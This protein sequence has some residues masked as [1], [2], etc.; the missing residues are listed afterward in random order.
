MEQSSTETQVPTAMPD[1]EEEDIRE[2]MLQ[3]ESAETLG[4]EADCEDEEADEEAEQPKPKRLGKLIRNIAAFLAFVCLLFLGIGWFF[5]IGW[6][7]NANAA[8]VNRSGKKN[9]QST[10]ESE[11]EKLKIA[12]NIVAAKETQP[13]GT[14]PDL[15]ATKNNDLSAVPLP[16]ET[17]SLAPPNIDAAHPTVK[18]PEYTAT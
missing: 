13:S 5:G 17:S 1:I 3:R 7:S 10:A 16:G 9:S 12:L 11:D 18:I 6:F 14:S 4:N 15:L 8:V 2:T